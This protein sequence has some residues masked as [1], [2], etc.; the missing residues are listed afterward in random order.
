MTARKRKPPTC[1]ACGAPV[2][3]AQTANGKRIMLDK[4]ADLSQ[5]SRHALSRDTG[6]RAHVRVLAVG[7]DPRPG[8]E[9]RHQ[10]H[11]ATCT[12]RQDLERRKAG[13]DE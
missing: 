9:K 5:T 3:W 13:G 1:R 12:K 6:L 4:L 2:V 7:E 10:P 8:V 11:Y